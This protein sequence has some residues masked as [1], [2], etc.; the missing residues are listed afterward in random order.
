MK[1]SSLAKITTVGKMVGRASRFKFDTVSNLA[2]SLRFIYLST[3]LNPPCRR[4]YSGGSEIKTAERYMSLSKLAKYET[5]SY[6]GSIA[7]CLATPRDQQVFRPGSWASHKSPLTA[8]TPG[9]VSGEGMAREP[10][11]WPALWVAGSR[12]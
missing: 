11:W 5:V 8:A 10:R 9:P 6:L 2:N 4:K 7:F 1:L 3:R 12:I